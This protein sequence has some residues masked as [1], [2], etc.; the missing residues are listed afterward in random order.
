MANLLDEP[1]EIYRDDYI[2]VMVLDEKGAG[3]AHHLYVILPIDGV[4]PKPLDSFQEGPIQEVGINGYTNEA[5]LAIVKHRLQC[6]QE[7]PFPSNYNETGIVGI[8]FAS[9]S[10]DM[11]TL[12][13]KKRGV[14]GKT[15]A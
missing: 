3:G 15:K 6:F 9:H 11:R 10:L 7:G 14:E 8:E 2:K 13:R 1:F 12:D 4:N 5:L